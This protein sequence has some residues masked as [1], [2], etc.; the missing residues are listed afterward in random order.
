MIGR[1]LVVAGSDSGA[2]AGIQADIKTIAALG[3]YATTAITAITAQD[4][5]G[6]HDVMRVPPEL[7]RRQMEVVLDDIGAD[8]IKTG[9]LHDAA[10][11]AAVVDIVVA[12]AATIPLVV[13]PVLVAS[14]GTR[15]MDEDA[16]EI[17]KRSLIPLTTVLTP[18][19]PEAA[20]LTGIAV[21]DL[22]AM[23]RAAEALVGLG[24]GA[25]LVKG[26]HVDGD[27]V[28]DVLFD[29]RTATVLESERIMTRH[30]H[31]TG[32]TLASAIAVG[33]AQGMP[34]LAAIRRARAYLTA[35][36]D[37][38]PGLGNGRGPMNHMHVLAR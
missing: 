5:R 24:A 30:T 19:A 27:T 8:C 6:V 17:L 26:G 38:A 1:V 23:Q 9:M 34:P 16:L 29:G 2:G 25:A 37:T 18:N 11:L 15:L 10:I 20:A 13:D 35:A 21:D 14:D 12:K 32:C 28:R 22:D 7:V 3:G 4:T 36:L 33:L 31:G